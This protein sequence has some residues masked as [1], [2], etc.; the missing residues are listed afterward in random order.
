MS[1]HYLPELEERFLRYVK[2]DTQSDETSNEAPSTKRQLALLRLLK[3]ELD[4]MGTSDARIT[5]YGCLLATIPPTSPGSKLPTVAL[6]AHGDTS[7]ALSGAN[8]KPIIHRHYD[9]SPITLPDDPSKILNEETAPGLSEKRGEDIVTAS[10][11]TLLGADDKA[12][13]AVIMTLAS[14]LL[15]HPEIPHGPLRLCFTPDEEIGRGVDHLTLEDLAADVAYTIDG[16][17]LGEVIYESF[18]ADKAVVE[19]AGVS[20][21]PGTAKGKMVNA[22]KLAAQFIETLP[23]Q[24]RTPETTDGREGFIHPY[25]I[26]G[27]AAH[28]ELLFILRDFELDELKA[29]GDLIRSV[30]ER[31]ALAE[32]RAKIECTITPQYRNMRY[33]IEDEMR[34]VELA[35]EAIKEAGIEPII[36]PIRGGTDGARLTEMGLMTPNLFCGMH[37]VHGPLEWVSLQDMAKATQVCLNLVCLW[38]AVPSTLPH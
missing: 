2:I 25:R 5:D 29:H 30:A 13:V 6:L 34:P 12:G 36:T 11:T 32:P 18:S 15:S 4:E 21:H 17:A 9:G 3:Q 35:I 8:V 37:N 28:V 38:A 33:W 23:Q 1:Q 16:G 27:T 31:L 24:T 10:G 14:H 20:I 7:P 22:L 19:I 26:S